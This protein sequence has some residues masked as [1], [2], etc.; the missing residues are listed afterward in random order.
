MKSKMLQINVRTKSG[1]QFDATDT[2]EIE[3]PRQYQGVMM[4]VKCGEKKMLTKSRNYFKMFGKSIP[5]V[6]QL[7]RWSDEGYC[8]SLYGHKVEP[9]GWDHQGSPSMMIVLGMI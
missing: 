5:T 9:D 4:V 3:F 2:C 7:T 8:K 6:D 1:I